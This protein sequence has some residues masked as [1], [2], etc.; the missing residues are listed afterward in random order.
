MTLCP[1]TI[2]PLL[3]H[4]LPMILRQLKGILGITG[5]CSIWIPSYGD[6]AW[7][8]Y[9]LIAEIQQPQ[10]N[11]LVWSPDTEKAFTVLQT[12]LLHAAALNLTTGSEFNLSLKEKIWPWEF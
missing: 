3:N 9:K 4:P 11:K 1:K 6:L 8:L 10:T 2:K 12:A 7:A 5:Y